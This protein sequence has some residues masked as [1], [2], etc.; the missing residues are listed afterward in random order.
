MNKG[1][2]GKFAMTAALVVG[3]AAAADSGNSKPPLTGAELEKG[4]R[5]EILTYPKLTLWDDVRFRISDGNVELQ[6][7]VNQ[8]YKK[9][10]LQRLVQHVPGVKSVTNEVKVLPLSNFDDELRIRV[11]RA[12][13]YD[14]TLSRYAMGAI[15][16]IHVIVE[17]GKVTLRGSV[18]NDMDKQIAG[19]R[20]SGAGM[21]FGAVVNDLH[22][23]NPAKK[24]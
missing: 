23:E 11:A 1:I 5:H 8:P 16:S 21:S 12:I 13:Y 22:V 20:A 15:P 4:V 7:A 9:D 18:M 6:G 3:I 14:P 2:L 10:D 24:G 19:M 17:N